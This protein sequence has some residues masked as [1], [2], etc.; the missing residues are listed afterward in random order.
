MHMGKLDGL[1]PQVGDALQLPLRGGMARTLRC[2]PDVAR[3]AVKVGTISGGYDLEAVWNAV[4]GRRI[5][6]VTLRQA[7]HPGLAAFRAPQLFAPLIGHG[8]RG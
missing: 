6:A 2:H 8:P 1:Y 5:G 7:S 3:P 4:N